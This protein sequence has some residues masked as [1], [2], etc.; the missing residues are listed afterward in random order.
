MDNREYLKFYSKS[1]E[2]KVLS[3]FYPIEIR[4]NKRI[5]KTGEHAFHGEKYRLLAKIYKVSEERNK[6]LKDYSEKFVNGYII[7]A[8]DAKIAG[9][10]RGLKLNDKEL[11]VWSKLSIE[12]QVKICIY[13]FKHN[14]EVREVLKLNKNKYILHQEN[15]AKE[16]T[17]WGGRI[18]KETN[19]IIGKNKLGKIWMKVRDYYVLKK[20]D[21]SDI[22]L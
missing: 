13:K 5:Y 1:K 7:E 18:S 2:G 19:K 3:N 6:E 4:I 8:K 12:V 21:K 22:F 16:N 20:I 17:I 9:G 14:N 11:K 10:K 15:R